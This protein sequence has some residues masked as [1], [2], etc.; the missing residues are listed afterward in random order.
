MSNDKPIVTALDV[1]DK[2][3]I[4]EDSKFYN[5]VD[6]QGNPCQYNPTGLHGEVVSIGHPT[7]FGFDVKVQWDNGK[8]N[9]YTHKDLEVIGVHDYKEG[10]SCLPPQ[11]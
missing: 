8:H 3:V 4:G 9:A 6:A 2:V 5:T 1:G 11:F 7:L 10:D